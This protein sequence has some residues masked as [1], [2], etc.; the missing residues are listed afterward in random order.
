MCDKKTNINPNLPES[1]NF[2]T[3]LH[4]PS[5]VRV[6]LYTHAV[7]VYNPTHNTVVHQYQTLH[8]LCS[9]ETVVY[10]HEG[11]RDL[12]SWLNGRS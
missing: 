9:I 7:R 12:I 5:G 4:T 8:A 6:N 3:I 11:Y 2:N 10:S 1:S